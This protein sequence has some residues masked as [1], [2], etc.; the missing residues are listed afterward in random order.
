VIVAVVGESQ[1]MTGEASS[2][3]DIGL[4]GSQLDLLKALK[5]TGKPLVSRAD[6][7]KTTYTSLGE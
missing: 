5:K 7:W 2:R 4:P 3:A 1:G 6:E